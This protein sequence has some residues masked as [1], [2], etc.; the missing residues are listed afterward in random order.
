M[1]DYLFVYGFGFY[2]IGFIL[3]IKIAWYLFQQIYKKV[4]I[5]F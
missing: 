5:F 3:K 1:V 4:H 2:I